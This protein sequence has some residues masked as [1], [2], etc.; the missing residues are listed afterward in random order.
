[1]HRQ[2]EVTNSQTREAAENVAQSDGDNEEQLECIQSPQRVPC[3]IE[4]NVES[5]EVVVQSKGEVAR[6]AML[7]H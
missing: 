2:L 6:L 5:H 3:D 4:C 7:C 1:M